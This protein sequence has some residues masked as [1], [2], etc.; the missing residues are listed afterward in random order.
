[1]LR[2]W[3]S[4]LYVSFLWTIDF[5]PLLGF[6]M[7]KIGLRS[8]LPSSVCSAGGGRI[9]VEAWYSTALDIEEV[10]SGF[11][12]TDAHVFVAEVVKSFDAVER[13]S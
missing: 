3:V 13:G 5:G 7:W 8:W 9:S 10:L 12:D 2:L 11:S 6:D 4:I 1:M